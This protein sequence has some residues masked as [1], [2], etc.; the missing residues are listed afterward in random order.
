MGKLGYGGNGLLRP[1]GVSYEDDSSIVQSRLDTDIVDHLQ[2]QYG[3]DMAKVL[4]PLLHEDYRTGNRIGPHHP[5]I[6]AEVLHAVREEMALHLS[7][8]ILRRTELGSVGHPGLAI[9]TAAASI[10]AKELNWTKTDVANEISAV[11][12]IYKNMQGRYIS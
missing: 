3:M 4:T 2:V 6:K 12:D 10:M 1:T 9:L 8:V 11:E 7:D 5:I